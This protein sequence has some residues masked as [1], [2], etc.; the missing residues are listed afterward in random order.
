[1]CCMVIFDSNEIVKC[2]IFVRIFV[3]VSNYRYVFLINR[4]NKQLKLDV[5]CIGERYKIWYNF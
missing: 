1:M 2:D 3:R 4:I 5:L